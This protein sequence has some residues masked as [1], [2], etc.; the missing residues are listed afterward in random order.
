[1]FLADRRLEFSFAPIKKSLN[2]CIPLYIENAEGKY[3]SPFHDIPIYANEAEVS[4]TCLLILQ[5]LK[6]SVRLLEK[7]KQPDTNHMRFTI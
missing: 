5:E 3:I 4:I 2:S 1:M 6:T 7:K